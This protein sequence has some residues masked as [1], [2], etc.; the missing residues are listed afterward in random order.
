MYGLM[1]R[2]A[3]TCLA[4]QRFHCVAG[5]VFPLLPMNGNITEINIKELEKNRRAIIAI[6]SLTASFFDSE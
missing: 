3:P 1:S 6:L 2:L 4:Q 5:A